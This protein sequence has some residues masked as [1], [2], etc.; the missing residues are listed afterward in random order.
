MY[1]VNSFIS[2]QIK[3]LVR[4]II[5]SQI[6]TTFYCLGDITFLK[7]YNRVM[8][9]ICLALDK[10]QGEENAYTGIL[11]PTL[12][13]ALK[14]LEE[15]KSN[16]IV[17]VCLPL[18]TVLIEAI[19]TRFHHVL[20]SADHQLAMALHPHFRLSLIPQ[21]NMDER[22][23]FLSES[24]AKSIKTQMISKLEYLL[25]QEGQNEAEISSVDLQDEFFGFLFEQPRSR[26]QSA[27]KLVDEFLKMSPQRCITDAC[28]KHPTIKRLFIKTNTAIP[29]SAAIERV[30]STAKDIL[31]PKRAGLSDTH[32]EMLLF[33]KA[34]A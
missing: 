27:S 21:S 4:P 14:K 34:N 23:S 29:S 10:L 18:V 1:N 22:Y 15:L 31:K 13:M 3:G 28:F 20:H 5:I 17:G 9:P 25:E 16:N 30:F 26:R 33:L 2:L 8:R 19:Q 24:I 11:W 6:F 12:F 32:F 7:E